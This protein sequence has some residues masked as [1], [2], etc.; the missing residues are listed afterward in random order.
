MTAAGGRSVPRWVLPVVVGST[1]VIAIALGVLWYVIGGWPRDHDRYGAVRIPGRQTLELPK[2]EVRL[3]FEGHVSGGGETRTLEDPPPGLEVRVR[4][5]S[6]R[7][8]MVERVSNSL[9][10]VFTGGRG[11][12]PF[13]KV[14]VPERGGYRVRA[15]ARGSSPGG[16]ITAGPKLW[17]PFDS[18][19]LGALSVFFGALL[20]LVFLELPLVL[21]AGLRSNRS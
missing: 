12:E 10:G 20:A 16:R 11:H 17:N 1:V 21:G 3:D 4:R 9:Y 13:G 19:L 18:R 5:R 7:P 15:V 14:D 8:L 2:G 6:G